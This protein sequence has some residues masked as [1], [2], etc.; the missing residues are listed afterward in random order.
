[1]AF[2]ARGASADPQLSDLIRKEQAA[3]LMLKDLLGPDGR[4]D[5]L[6][7]EKIICVVVEDDPEFG[8]QDPSQAF[9]D[10]F[11]NEMKKLGADDLTFAMGS[12]C[13]KDPDMPQVMTFD[14]QLASYLVAEIESEDANGRS[15]WF[16]HGFNGGRVGGAIYEL[17]DRG[18]ELKFA[19][20]K[21][22]P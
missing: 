13:V 15:E 4:P 18:A 21:G 14:G 16:V 5:W 11:A 10:L 20:I 2:A 6:A 7:D 17:I 12:A 3:F 1:M 9:L 8:W 22:Y 19:V